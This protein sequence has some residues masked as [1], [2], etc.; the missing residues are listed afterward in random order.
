MADFG[1]SEDLIPVGLQGQIPQAEG[2]AFPMA[3]LIPPHLLGGLPDTELIP[4]DTD[5]IDILKSGGAG[6]AAGFTAPV[7]FFGTSLEVLEDMTGIPIPGEELGEIARN[8]QEFWQKRI[9]KSTAERLIGQA[10][11]TIG[12]IASTAAVIASTGGTAAV[13]EGEGL[14]L[15]LAA[16]AGI[17]K[18]AEARREGAPKLNALGAGFTT[19]ASEYLTEKIPIN[20]LQK[21]GLGFFTRLAGG[22]ITDVPGEMINTAIEMSYIDKHILKRP[23]NL[24]WGEY[25]KVLGETAAVSAISV[26]GLSGASQV[27]NRGRISEADVDEMQSAIM[28]AI[29]GIEPV[30]PAD[31]VT[32]QEKQETTELG[33]KQREDSKSEFPEGSKQKDPISPEESFDIKADTKIVPDPAE[34]VEREPGKTKVDE[35]YDKQNAYKREELSIKRRSK[36]AREAFVR[37]FVDVSGNI[38]KLLASMGND[39]KRVA[40]MRDLIAGASSKSLDDFS[41]ARREIFSGLDKQQ[42]E[43]FDKYIFALRHIEIRNIKGEKFTLPDNATEQE[44]Q[45]FIDSVPEHSREAMIDRSIKWSNAMKYVLNLQLQEGL[46][47]DEQFKSM[48][49]KGKYYSPRQVLQYTDPLVSGTDRQGRTISVPDSGLKKLSE[50]GSDKLVEMD[51]ELLLQQVLARTWTRIF[52]N[53]ANL[54]MLELARTNPENGLVREAAIVDSTKNV[55]EIVN[56]ETGAVLTD[57]A[58]ESKR[59]A[60]EIIKGD[61]DIYEVVKVKIGKPIFEGPKDGTEQRISVVEKGRRVDMIMP[62]DMAQEWVKSDPIL[63]ASASWW[64]SWLSGN[65]IL[66]AMATGLNP[67]FAITNIPRDIMHIYLTTDEYNSFLPVALFQ[68]GVD[69]KAVAN[70]AELKKGLYK[71]YI[72]NGGGTEFLSHQGR[73]RTR[74]ALT[75]TQGAMSALEDIMGYMGERSEILTRL[76]LMRRAMRNGKSEQEATWIARNY[77]DFSQGGSVAKAFDT[78]IPFLNASI[79]GTRGILRAAKQRKGQFAWKVTNI[80][81]L[82]ISLFLANLN[83]RDKETGKSI[84]D[85]VPAGEQERNWIITTPLW[86]KDKDGTKRYYYLKIPK[87]QGQR[88][89]ATGFEAMAKKH[90]GME[91]DTDI[92]VD[93]ILEFFPVLPSE[94]LPPTIDA[95]LGYMVNKDF[96]RREDIWKGAD[97]EPQA[98]FNKYTPQSYVSIGEKTGLSP[99]RMEYVVK[100]YT[101]S[102]NI[103]T[104]IVGYGAKQIFDEL[105]EADMK[106]VTEELFLRKPGVRRFL[107]STKPEIEQMKR[108]KEAKREANTQRKIINDA[109]DK[110]TERYFNKQTKLNE[111]REFIKRQPASETSRLQKRFRVQNR[112]KDVPNRQYWISLSSLPPQYRAVNYFNDWIQLD[113][114]G[115]QAMDLMSLRVPGFRSESFNREFSKMLNFSR[116]GER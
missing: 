1:L 99:E 21:P 70:D 116:Q 110:L 3:D 80:G 91:V 2:G 48:N 19:A 54:A 97:V 45:D 115:R 108:A 51:S 73:F 34:K 15:S 35:L 42:K 37:G 4:E 90:L 74:G 103:W 77:L 106:K 33:K 11:E 14:L 94:T 18:T 101:T 95:M 8:A 81:T 82:A 63:S 44:F 113:A 5:L 92:V 36:K 26:V 49:S 105:D 25:L 100:Q 27:L 12:T 89:M 71:I 9:G 55:F 23:H 102:G 16:G 96:W 29:N 52:R 79:Q 62:K 107:K 56:K 84:L 43:M 109:F 76:A 83:N 111:I 66:K 7:R 47:T 98:E 31:T 17:E 58:Y 6:L 86:F 20:I 64:I 50:D 13:A 53:R 40:M 114:A 75:K 24:S 85:D 67:E 69:I 32:T 65:K 57:E 30:K 59:E 22:V 39:G 60:E 10:T 72:E 78:M 46:I 93:S 41:I 38:K 104:S 61:E 88:V 28:K 112:L 87:D 68:M